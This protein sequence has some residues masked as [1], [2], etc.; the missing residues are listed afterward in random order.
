[1]KQKMSCFA[2]KLTELVFPAHS[3]TPYHHQLKRPLD[4]IKHGGRGFA[5]EKVEKDD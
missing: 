4:N 1:M 5:G 2:K 3:F